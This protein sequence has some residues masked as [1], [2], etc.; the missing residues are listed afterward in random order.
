MTAAGAARF[1]ARHE[2]A[3][4]AGF[5]RALRGLAVSS[6]GLGTY[7]GGVDEAASRNY[8]DAI[9]A[10]ARGGVN[11]FDTAINYRAQASERDLGEAIRDLTLAG[12]VQRDE[13][14]VCTKA[15][16]ITPGAVTEGTLGEA[17]I[18]GGVHSMAPDFLEDQLRRSRENLGM[19]CVDVFYL[20]NP[21][22]QLRF[23][24][25][26]EFQA[27]IAAAFRRC[28]QLCERGW[29]MNYGVATW[30]G[31]R[32]KEGQAERLSLPRLME[33]ARQAGGEDHHF[34][35]I[36]LPVNL[37]MPEAFTLPHAMMGG[38]SVN[39]LECAARAGMTVVASAP[40]LQGRLT[41]G[42]PEALRTK[43]PRA[44]SD[45]QF[46]LEF[47]RSTPGVT[48]ALAGMGRVEHVRENLELRRAAPV[49]AEEYVRLFARG[50]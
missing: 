27:R 10:A 3:G 33:L 35:F 5:F 9:K 30:S 17:E 43:W 40:L 20:H 7:L 47:A 44:I 18:A 13:L 16:F 50:A 14:L 46:A 32:L 23:V 34:R 31:L 11:V 6:I 24:A 37:A 39:V 36:Q 15:G 38:E 22:T 28:E 8:R 42:L 19:D 25:G 12:T 48:V 2:E 49:A 41:A 21:E 29:A 26:A 1:A 45:A 4:R